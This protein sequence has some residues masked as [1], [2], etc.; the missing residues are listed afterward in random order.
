MTIRVLVCSIAAF[1]VPSAF[2]Q[3][4]A[5]QIHDVDIRPLVEL[6]QKNYLH[7]V[8]SPFYLW[9]WFNAQG[10]SDIWR[11]QLPS[12]S[13]AGLAHFSLVSAWHIVSTGCGAAK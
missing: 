5:Q 10:H 13:P 3:M 7:E 6:V 2:A 1:L 4:T 9:H 11:S 8:Q 12:D